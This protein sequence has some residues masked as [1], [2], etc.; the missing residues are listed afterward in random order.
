M[1]H[2]SATLLRLLTEQEFVGMRP[3]LVAMRSE[4]LT[5]QGMERVWEADK[6]REVFVVVVI[7]D[8]MKK[9][10]WKSEAVALD[11]AG[12]DH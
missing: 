11:Y 5:H 7:R 4:I 1:Y 12:G 6:R 10:R 3:T 9:G 2:V 8:I